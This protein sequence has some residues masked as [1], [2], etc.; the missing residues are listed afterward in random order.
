MC[1]EKRH[2]RE[3]GGPSE[4][5]RRTGSE[6]IKS[7]EDLLTWVIQQFRLFPMGWMAIKKK[8]SIL[9]LAVSPEQRPK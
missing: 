8:Q 5:A 7:L 1:L 4:V 2:G 3:G 9:L 6:R